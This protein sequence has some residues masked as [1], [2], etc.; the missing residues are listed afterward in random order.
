MLLESSEL[1]LRVSSLSSEANKKL[2]DTND[3]LR[4]ALEVWQQNG[5][6]RP[7]GCYQPCLIFPFKSEINFSVFLL[8]FLLISFLLLSLFDII[9]FMDCRMW[10]HPSI[11]LFIWFWDF[12]GC[13]ISQS[14]KHG[15][16]RSPSPSKRH[17]IST[18]YSM[19]KKKKALDQ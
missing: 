8:L 1:M 2:H 4:S 12:F 14:R 19:T 10:F 15:D 3:D 6:F 5:S 11:H 9:S 16:S 7:Y 17:S 13:F 18:L